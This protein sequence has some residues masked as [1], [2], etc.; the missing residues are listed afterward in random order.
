M[1]AETQNV[2]VFTKNMVALPCRN[3]REHDTSNLKM[4]PKRKK[5]EHIENIRYIFSISETVAMKQLL[6]IWHFAFNFVTTFRRTFLFNPSPL[7]ISMVEAVWILELGP[8][9]LWCCFMFLLFS[10]FFKTLRDVS[11]SQERYIWKP[12]MK[13]NLNVVKDLN[14]KP[15]FNTKSMRILDHIPKH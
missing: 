15:L 13:H 4:L 3:T 11:F 6:K 9:I 5:K 2:A 8:I 10:S 12:S 7:S 14:S 1:S